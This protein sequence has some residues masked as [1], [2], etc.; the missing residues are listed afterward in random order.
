M[1]WSE[2]QCELLR[3]PGKNP[4]QTPHRG[5]SNEKRANRRFG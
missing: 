1:I 5:L 3:K 4:T 2:M